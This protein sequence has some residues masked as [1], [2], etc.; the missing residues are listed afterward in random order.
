MR[1]DDVAED[2]RWPRWCAA[3]R[4][5]Q[6]RSALSAPLVA[7]DQALGAMKVYAAEPAAYGP[8]EEH[9]LSM[10]ASQA[11]ILIANMQSHEKAQ[12]LSE[13]LRAA[14]QS[15]DLIGQAKGIIMER[16]GV[17]EDRAFAILAA[18]SQK[19]NRKLTEVARALV[20]TATRRRR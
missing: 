18:M 17:G 10:L 5:N 8:R 20:D 13:G 7:G 1:I 4:H 3:I 16:D 14:L 19:E 11:S 15:R 6:V 12:H 2:P 9:L